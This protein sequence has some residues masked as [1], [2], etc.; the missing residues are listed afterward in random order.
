M[1]LP[2]MPA[3]YLVQGDESVSEERLHHHREILTLQ[4]LV[5]VGE[6]VDTTLGMGREAVQPSWQGWTDRF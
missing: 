1:C 6:L 4:V 2:E 5:P 3:A